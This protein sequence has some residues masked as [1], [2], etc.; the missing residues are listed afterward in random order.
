MPRPTS[1]KL[2]DALL[3]HKGTDLGMVLRVARRGRGHGM[4]QRDGQTLGDQHALLAELL[5]D[6]TDGRRVVVAEHNVGPRVDHLADFDEVEAGGA[7]QGFLGE[8]LWSGAIR[9]V[10]YAM[11]QSVEFISDF[12]Q[13]TLS[14]ETHPRELSKDSELS[15]GGQTDRTHDLKNSD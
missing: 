10:I 2:L 7:G 8:C 6:A 15:A 11:S 5:P 4:V 1:K 14:A 9:S 13:V 12:S 3:G